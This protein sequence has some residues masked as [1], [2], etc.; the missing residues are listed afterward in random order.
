MKTPKDEAK[1]HRC[2]KKELSKA[3]H[4]QMLRA[5]EAEEQSE[6]E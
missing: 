2:L 1:A 3:E 6:S 4:D 5:A